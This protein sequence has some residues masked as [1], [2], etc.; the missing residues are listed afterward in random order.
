MN[1]AQYWQNLAVWHVEC[2]ENCAGGSFTAAACP[3]AKTPHGH[4]RSRFVVLDATA[5]AQGRKSSTGKAPGLAK[6][7]CAISL[8]LP[9][10]RLPHGYNPVHADK[11]E[12]VG[13]GHVK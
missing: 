8:L 13:T 2:G 4:R 10:D 3:P 5:P 7:G 6:W 12:Q 11:V 9:P 1:V